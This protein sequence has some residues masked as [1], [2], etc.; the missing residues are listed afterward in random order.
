MKI[1]EPKFTIVYGTSYP[2]NSNQ[3]F[4][5]VVS[6]RRILSVNKSEQSY[7]STLPISIKAEKRIYTIAGELTLIKIKCVSDL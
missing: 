4:N 5:A 2:I 7:K 3:G 6:S 1:A